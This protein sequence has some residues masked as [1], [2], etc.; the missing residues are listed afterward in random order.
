MIKRTSTMSH[1]AWVSAGRRAQRVINA[2]GAST[3]AAAALNVK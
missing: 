3:A 2:N 1:A